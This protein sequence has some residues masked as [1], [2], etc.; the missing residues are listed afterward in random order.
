MTGELGEV[1]RRAWRWAV[2]VWA[3][4]AAVGGGL[5]LWLQDSTEPRP[6]ARWERADPSEEPAAPLLNA[7]ECPH[8]D[9]ATA[10]ACV[11]ARP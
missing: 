5:T 10:V 8:D 6:P 11:Y 4:A 1:G 2:A 3:I 7:T 9:G